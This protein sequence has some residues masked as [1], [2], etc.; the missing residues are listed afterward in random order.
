MFFDAPYPAVKSRQ[1]F[2][3]LLTGSEIISPFDKNSNFDRLFPN[4]DSH[5]GK[6]FGNLIALPIVAIFQQYLKGS[7]ETIAINGD[8]PA[9]SRKSKLDQIKSATKVLKISCCTLIHYHN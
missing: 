7:M 1:L 2:L 9:Q 4:Q 3:T 6:G 5:S 8:D